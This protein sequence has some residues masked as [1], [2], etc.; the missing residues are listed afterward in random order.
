MVYDLTVEEN[1]SYCANGYIVHNC[2]TSA[3]VGVGYSMAELIK[4]CYIIKKNNN[5]ET[6]IIADGGFKKYPDI[7]KA[8]ALG[9]DY[10]MLGGMFNKLLE[11]SAETFRLDTNNEKVFLSLEEAYEAFN[12]DIKLYKNF[13]GM[14]TKDV[15]IKW[16]KTKLTTSEG[17]SKINEV[18]YTLN[19][20]L[21]NFKDY[22]KSAMS[23]TNSRT[24]EEFI[25]KPK[26]NSISMN[27]FNRFNK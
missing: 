21:D 23:Y 9:A 13:R 5:F 18:E 27:S 2:L 22:L 26:L 16:G 20:W 8:L 24:I 25:G 1:H 17:I 14:S 7:I 12:S 3:N 19:G 11:S 10:V 6:K 15:Q 4:E